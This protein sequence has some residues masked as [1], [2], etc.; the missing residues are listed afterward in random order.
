MS[1]PNGHQ[2]QGNLEEYRAF[3][4][5][6]WQAVSGDK[7]TWRFSLVQIRDEERKLG[8]ACLEELFLYLK[9]E[10]GIDQQ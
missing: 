10:L 9:G 4:L 7:S 8:F 6:C 5:R 1:Y 2:T 3:L